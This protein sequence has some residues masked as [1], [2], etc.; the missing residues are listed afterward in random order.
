[1]RTL[2]YLLL[3][4]SLLAGCMTPYQPEGYTGGYTDTQLGENTFRV[5]F[6][7]N[8]E[9]SKAR[10]AD[11]A[12]LRAA[13]VA[14]TNGFRY[15]VVSESRIDSNV[16]TYTSPAESHTTGN[17]HIIGNSIYGSATTITSGG[18]V[19]TGST[20]SATNVIVCFKDKPDVI[21]VVFDAEF[22][23]KSLKKKYKITN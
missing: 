14:I 6:R 21:G 18:Q 16:F 9:V 8:V 12:L 4:G 2:F 17:A 13:E 19:G 3:M 11:Y 23:T 20:P 22:V 1:M 5:T 15:F 7:G 10:A